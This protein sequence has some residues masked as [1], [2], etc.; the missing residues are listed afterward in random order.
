[1]TDPL[2]TR[3]SQRYFGTQIQ[4]IVFGV[5]PPGFDI[6]ADMFEMVNEAIL[7]H[8]LFQGYVDSYSRLLK[9]GKLES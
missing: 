5:C 1:M 2:A 7:V 4:N 3:L 6:S 8:P 9:K